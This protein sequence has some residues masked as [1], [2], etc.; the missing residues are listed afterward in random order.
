ML[1]L[2]S[3]CFLSLFEQPLCTYVPYI[4]ARTMDVELTIGHLRRVHSANKEQPAR[5]D[6]I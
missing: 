3:H 6:K 1:T 5:L 4:Y 2:R